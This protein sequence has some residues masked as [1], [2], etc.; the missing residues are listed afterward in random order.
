MD[1]AAHGAGAGD[2]DVRHEPHHR[3]DPSLGPPGCRPPVRL[4]LCRGLP[5]EA[6]D[7]VRTRSANAATIRSVIDEYGQGGASA[8]QDA[9]LTD[10]GERPL[11]VLTAATGHDAAESAAQNHL[12]TL[13]TDSTHRIVPGST[14]GSLVADENDANAT[15][16]RSSTSPP[17]S[18]R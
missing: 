16:R 10:L 1:V 14:D 8:R 18:L 5:A 7:E 2:L 6:R 12:A 13:S 3:T 4:A 15:A 11:T 9:A 17:R